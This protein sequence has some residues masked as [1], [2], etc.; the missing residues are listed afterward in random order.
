MNQE[1]L[2][3]L[4]ID[5]KQ[6]RNYKLISRGRYSATID[7]DYQNKEKRTSVLIL[8]KEESE[9]RMFDF[10]KVENEYTVRAIEYEYNCRL[11]AYLVYTDAG[12][13]TLQNKLGDKAFRKCPGAIEAIFDW[14]KAVT[15]GLKK[16]HSDSYVH[17]NLQASSILI[18]SENKAKIGVLNFARHS[19]TLNK[20]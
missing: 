12:E 17:L 19:S 13:C 18:T 11:Q 20:R 8:A 14:I 2:V 9:A 1:N 3:D 5:K 10:E 7:L 16:L 4:V 6:F 15:L